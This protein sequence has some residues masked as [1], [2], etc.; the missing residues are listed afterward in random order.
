MTQN[1]SHIDDNALWN[2][3]DEAQNVLKL[4]NTQFEH[5][6]AKDWVKV[7]TETILLLEGELHQRIENQDS[8]L[9]EDAAK[10]VKESLDSLQ[11][12]QTTDDSNESFSD[13][14][15]SEDIDD[16]R[17]SE[18]EYKEVKKQLEKIWEDIQ[19]EV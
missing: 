16:I 6:Q 4:V 13:D 1:I 3:L 15:A 12:G 5:H 18:T 10:Q 14:L 7:L 2:L 17:E 11:S 8:K 19:S 9:I